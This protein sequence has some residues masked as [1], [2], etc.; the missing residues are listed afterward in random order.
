MKLDTK[1]L[2]DGVFIASVALYLILVMSNLLFYSN[3]KYLNSRW[4]IYP[5]LLIGAVWVMKSDVMH[6]AVKKVSR[7]WTLVFGIVAAAASYY[8]TG[9]VYHSLFAAVIMTAIAWIFLEKQ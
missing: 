6:H 1:K 8:I 5:V 9:S 7:K 3:S 2:L 4:M